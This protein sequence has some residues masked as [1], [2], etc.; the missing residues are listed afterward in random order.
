[1]LPPLRHKIGRRVGDDLCLT[2]WSYELDMI[3][4]DRAAISRTVRH[5]IET[6]AQDGAFVYGTTY[7]TAEVA[8]ET[9]DFMCAE[10]LRGGN[11]VGYAPGAPTSD[12]TT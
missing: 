4:D 5:Q 11:K 2:G 8:P 7:L 3:R 12:S 10:I 1:M 9:V 6:A